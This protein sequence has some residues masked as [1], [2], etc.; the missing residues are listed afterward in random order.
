MERP[1]ITVTV[2]EAAQIFR[3][4]GVSIS[5]DALKRGI[6]EKEFPIGTA[7]KLTD[8]VFIIYRKPLIDYLRSVGAEI[9]EV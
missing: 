5:L 8:W 6:I 7:I 1:K 3:D 4:A 2:Q 9:R